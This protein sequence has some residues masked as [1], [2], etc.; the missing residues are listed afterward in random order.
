VD[1]VICRVGRGALALNRPLWHD[2]WGKEKRLAAVCVRAAHTD[3]DDL[4][5]CSPLLPA[6]LTLRGLQ[7]ATDSFRSH[8]HMPHVHTR[9][10]SW[11]HL[12]RLPSSY[13]KQSIPIPLATRTCPL[14]HV[15]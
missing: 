3:H 11:P 5:S 1:E 7:A 15:S 8:V 14:S 9:L 6:L 10:R 12:S 13:M 2:A 4:F